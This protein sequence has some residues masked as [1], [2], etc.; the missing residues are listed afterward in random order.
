MPQLF[1][2]IYAVLLVYFTVQA[3]EKATTN[4]DLEIAWAKYQ[5]I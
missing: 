1:F 3:N 2:V 5:V 4:E